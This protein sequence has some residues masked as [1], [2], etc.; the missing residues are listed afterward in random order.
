MIVDVLVIIL[1]E[2][3]VLVEILDF[4]SNISFR[5]VI[6]VLSLFPELF[7]VEFDLPRENPVRFL[8][9]EFKDVLSVTE[10]KI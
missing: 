9:W 8:R 2:N 5:I 4:I 1:V 6:N 10:H 7:R 3:L